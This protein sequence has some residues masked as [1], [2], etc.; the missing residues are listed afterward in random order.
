MLILTMNYVRWHVMGKISL[1]RLI[2]ASDFMLFPLQ[3]YS[4]YDTWGRWE[5]TISDVCQNSTI[6]LFSYSL[7]L[8][9]ALDTLATLGNTTEFARVY[10]LVQKIDFERDINVSVFETNI[11]GQ[12]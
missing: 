1:N 12:S 8:V 7:S 3:N 5:T 2:S 9:D 4:S 11:R 10:E 6:I